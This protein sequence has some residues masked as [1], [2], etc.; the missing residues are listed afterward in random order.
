[1]L[2]TLPIRSSGGA[3]T[4][5][6]ITL[7]RSLLKVPS[8]RPITAQNTV[9]GLILAALPEP[10]SLRFHYDIEVLCNSRG[11]GNAAADSASGGQGHFK[12]KT[13]TQSQQQLS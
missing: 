1:M 9:G 6:V 2:A 7:V 13:L 3:A 10:H 4:E 8:A 12:V 5:G 11:N